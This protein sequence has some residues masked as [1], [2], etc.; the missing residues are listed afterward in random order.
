MKTQYTQRRR[1]NSKWKTAL[2]VIVWA[3]LL[4]LL[5]SCILY[6]NQKLSVNGT[7]AQIPH[8]TTI[9]EVS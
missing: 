2:F 4:T 7:L 9:Q 5:L 1:W 3:I 8:F 6:Q